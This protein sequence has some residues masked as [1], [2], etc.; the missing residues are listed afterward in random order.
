MS[1]QVSIELDFESY[2]TEAEI[3]NYL[4]DLMD[5]DTLGY[6]VREPFEEPFDDP[7]RRTLIVPHVIRNTLK[8]RGYL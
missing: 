2:P 7:V 6:E 1:Y 8:E 5:S 4:R 3:Y